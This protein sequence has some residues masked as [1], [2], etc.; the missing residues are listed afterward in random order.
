MTK[1][2]DAGIPRNHINMYPMAPFSEFCV[3]ILEVLLL[4][5]CILDSNARAAFGDLV[6]YRHFYNLERMLQRARTMRVG[7]PGG[8]EPTLQ[9]ARTT[10]D[11]RAV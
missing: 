11:L 2:T 9:R 8:V 4:S 7:G 1:R 3:F 10:S 5:A 6:R